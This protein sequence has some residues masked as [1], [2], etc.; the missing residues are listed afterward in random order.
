MKEVARKCQQRETFRRLMCVSFLNVKSVYK[1]QENIVR[2]VCVLA[3]VLQLITI[4]VSQVGIHKIGISYNVRY[5]TLTIDHS[6]CS[7][8][9]F[10]F[11]LG[12]YLTEN[13]ISLTYK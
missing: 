8:L 6:R 12:S 1:F 4:A 3:K 11:P 10:V 5:S 7:T 2:I 13:T 9:N